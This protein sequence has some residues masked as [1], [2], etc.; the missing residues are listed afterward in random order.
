MFNEK[1]SQV[2]IDAVA[3]AVS[4]QIDDPDVTVEI[5]YSVDE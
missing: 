5:L 4:C 3:E 2:A 1:A